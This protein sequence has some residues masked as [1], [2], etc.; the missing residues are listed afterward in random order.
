VAAA[1]LA[2]ALA[3]A[4]EA[5][6]ARTGGDGAARRKLPKAEPGPVLAVV[7][8]ARQR[9]WVWGSSG[10]MAQ[11]PVSTGVEGHRT[12]AGVFSVVQKRRFHRSNIYSNAPMPF[13]QRITWSGIALHAG[14][15]PGY[16]ASHGCI[17]L[18]PAF[19]VELW[20][21]TRVGARVV[22]VPDDPSVFHIEHTRLP[23]PLLTPAPQEDDGVA[24]QAG[25]GTTGLETGSIHAIGITGDL[26]EEAP[27]Q[28]VRL[29]NPIERA[30]AAR[31][32][33]VADA[34]AKARA[35]KAAFAA[36]AAKSTEASRAIAA[37]RKAERA[38]ETAAARRDA[39]AEAIDAAAPPEKAERATARLAEAEATV[40][41]LEKAVEEA[42]AAEAAK[43]PEAMAAAKA[44]WEAKQANAA[45]AAAL[46]AT[47][48]STEP[49]SI[50]VSKKAGRVYVRRAWA[51]IHEAPV[52]FA[53]PELPVGTHLYLATAP[54][55][56][57]KAMRWLAV[58]IPPRPASVAAQ[59]DARAVPA[60]TASTEGPA[61]PDAMAALARFQL[62]PETR[63]F[64]E[65]RLWTGASLIV[66]DEGM[67]RETGATT[68]FIV[69]TR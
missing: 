41:E 38:L 25:T 27:P 1:G 69:L 63:R 57:E 31:A 67:S 16:P 28:P 54:A 42:R 65:D 50:L 40:A 53:E 68:D 43:T 5:A 7:S 64:I 44:A 60:S 22:I 24:A 52:T 26:V 20:G 8:L 36:S 55:E 13:M 29:L 6:E 23:V 34:S 39:A 59:G 37:L 4:P 32:H 10:L 61:A 49:I 58:S 2:L 35:A 17:R 66:S 3:A 33:A 62:P 45:A 11:S 47:E 18:P 51:P 9:I 12:P 56:G 15:V 21:M 19:A 46:E 14:V 48:R 30:R